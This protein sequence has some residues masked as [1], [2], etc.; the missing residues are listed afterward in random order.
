MPYSYE[1]ADPINY[2]LLEDFAKR[3]RTCP[4]D[5]EKRLWH[6]L[7]ADQ[8]GVS[9][10]RQHII[11]EFI[12]DFVCLNEKLII[13]V[14]GGYHQLPTQ[15]VNDEQRS[16]WLEGHGFKVI[17][18]TNEQVLFDID[19]VINEIKKHLKIWNKQR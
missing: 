4:T 18:F 19:N 2:A 9:F 7:K 8:L 5:A 13:E 11:G 12:A 15:Q 10:R 14:D 17:R 6:I 16:Q 1:T 3:L